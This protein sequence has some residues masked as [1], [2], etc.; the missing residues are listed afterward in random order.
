LVKLARKY[1]LKEFSLTVDEYNDERKNHSDAGFV[2]VTSD[3]KA[4]IHFFGTDKEEKEI[5]KKFN[6]DVYEDTE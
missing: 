1:G 3:R 6:I 4:T 5:D 2:F